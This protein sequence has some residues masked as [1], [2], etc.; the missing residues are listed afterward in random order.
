MI[1][2]FWTIGPAT[3]RACILIATKK[4]KGDYAPLFRVDILIQFVFFI[5]FF[6]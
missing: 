1:G 3:N 4:Q 5:A 2:L 6:Q